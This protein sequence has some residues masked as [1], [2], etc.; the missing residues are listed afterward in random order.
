M[1]GELMLNEEEALGWNGDGL[2][3]LEDVIELMEGGGEEEKMKDLREAFEMYDG[4]GSGFITP[5]G[6]NKMLTKLGESKSID[7]CMVMIKHFDINGDGVI[8]FDEFRVMMR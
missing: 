7:E 5:Q 2:L 1:G 6:L 8:S 4:E 3:D